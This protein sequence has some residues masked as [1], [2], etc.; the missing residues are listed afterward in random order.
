MHAYLGGPK[1]ESDQ[2]GVLNGRRRP[3]GEAR[4]RIRAVSQRGLF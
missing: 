3:V 4:F 1:I 2:K